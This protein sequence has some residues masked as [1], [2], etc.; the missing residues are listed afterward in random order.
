M[1]TVEIYPTVVRTT[2]LG[3]CSMVAR[4]G[5]IAAPQVISK[6]T[7]GCIEILLDRKIKD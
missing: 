1:F 6:Y 7:I 4:L 2:G 5:S 3:L